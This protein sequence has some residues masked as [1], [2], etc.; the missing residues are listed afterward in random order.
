MRRLAAIGGS[1]AA[2]RSPSRQMQTDFIFT[3]DCTLRASVRHLV[4]LAP[5]G[6]RVEARGE[7][8]GFI[9]NDC[10]LR[11]SGSARHLASAGSAGCRVAARGEPAGFIFTIDCRDRDPAAG[12]SPAPGLSWV[13]GEGTPARGA[14]RLHLHHRLP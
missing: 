3:I 1:V 2:A 11:A 10:T 12:L 8:T 7:P 13:S 14:R 9:F 6:C 4:R 5:A